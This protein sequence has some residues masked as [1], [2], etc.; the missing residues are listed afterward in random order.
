MA[1]EKQQQTVAKNVSK[2]SLCLALPNGH[3]V[4]I[5]RKGTELPVKRTIKVTT[6]EVDQPN[7]C[8]DIR[9]GENLMAED[10]FAFSKIK[11]DNIPKGAA[12]APVIRVT[13]KSYINSV[14]DLVIHY[15]E[16][17]AGQTLTVF[18][19]FGLSQDEIKAIH[20]KVQEKA[21]TIVPFD[22]GETQKIIPL[23][24]SA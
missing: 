16:K 12:G 11:L 6:T 2:H 5:I 13:F 8:L 20:K 21:K 10:N 22:M 24:R 7:I 3:C 14:Y 17:D 15:T 9:L 4:A 19:S 23:G 1:E 18:P